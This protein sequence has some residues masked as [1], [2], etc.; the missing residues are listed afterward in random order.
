MRKFSLM[1]LLCFLALGMKAQ[2]LSVSNAPSNG[3]WA[4]NTTWYTIKNKTG[5]YVSTASDYC[6]TEG[7]LRLHNSTKPADNDA[8]AHWC[9]VGSE[10]NG[11]KFYNKASG[12]G[13]ALY[14]SRVLDSGSASFYMEADGDAVNFLFDIANSQKSG[15]I[16]IKD[17]NN[18]NNYWNKRGQNLA[19]WNSTG[20]TNDD[21][22]SFQFVEV[23]V[24]TEL[25]KFNP[26]K[27][28]TVSTSGRGGWSVKEDGSQFCSTADGGLGTNVDAANTRN[29]FAI[30]TVDNENYYLFSVHA[31]K[32][33]KRDRTLVAGPGDP[34]EFAQAGD[35]VRVRVNFKGIAD[36]YIN[37]GGSNQMVINN[38][39]TLDAGN[40]VKFLESG[41]FNP[42]AALA[43]LAPQPD[44]FSTEESPKWHSVEFKTGGHF[45]SDKGNGQNLTTT[46]AAE[47]DA[48]LWIFIGKPEGFK[49]KNRAGNYVT[50]NSGASRFASSSTAAD[51]VEMSFVK[52]KT[53]GTWEIQR[54]GSS[55]CMNQ[56]GGTGV[57]VALGEWTAGDANN[58]VYLN[59]VDESTLETYMEPV[60]SNDGTDNWFMIKFAKNGNH[61]SSGGEG[62]QA[63]TA[64]V[65][66]VKSQWWKFV[67]TADNFQLVNKDG[68]YATMKA[69]TAANGQT[70]N[71]LL[72][73][74]STA[75]EHGFRIEKSKRANYT[76]AYEIRYNGKA[77]DQNSFNQWGGANAGVS[78]GLWTAHSD[79]NNPL[80]IYLPA[81]SLASV[82]DIE[83][84]EDYTPESPLTLWYKNAASNMDVDDKW[85][86]YSLPIGNGQ[87]GA[88]IFGGI[89]REQVQFNE[90]TLWSG[91]KN[92]KSSEYGDYE[93]FGS[94]YI[95]DIS[96]VFGEGKGV[97]N[98]YRQLDLSNATA[99][100]HY[101][102]TDGSINFTREYIAS[103]PD[104]VVAMRLT[105]DKPGNISIN[106]TFEAGRPGLRA[107]TTY[108]NGTASFAGKLETISY[109]AL[110]K[111]VPTNGT[112]TTGE[113]GI[114]V[115]GA[116]EVLIILGGDTDFDAYNPN[117]VS[118]TDEL[119][120]RVEARVNSAAAKDWNALYTAH[121]ED[122]KHYFDRCSFELAG[123]ANTMPTDDLVREYAKRTTGTESYALMLEQLYFAYGRYLEICSSRGV[124]LP[125]NLQ[126]I[127]N[128]S[129]EPAWNADIHANINVQMNYWPAEPTNMSEMHLPFLNYIINMANSAEW[130]KLA[131]DNGATRDE[132]WTFLT[133]NNIFGGF[134][135][136]AS[137]AF[138]NNAWYCSHLWQHY[139]YTLD[140]EFLARAFPAMWGASLF[141][142]ERVVYNEQD[143]TYEC[144][145]EYSPEHGPGAQNATAHSQQLV[146]E[147]FDNTLKA[148]EVL[149]AQN[150]GIDA[151]DIDALKDR[152]S[153][154]D[155]GLA[156]ETYN[157]DW[158]N[159]IA[160]GSKLLREWKYSYYTA[161]QNG[162][163][164]MSHL[165]CL[166]P[167]AQV[168]GESE[169][170][171]AAINSMLLRG[172][173]STGW[174]M[175]W[176]INLWARALDGNHSH[177][178]LELALRHHSVSGGGVYYNL[179]DS[180]S[181]F[182]IDGNFGACAG[183]A[184]MLFQSHSDVL[185][186]LPA[187]PDVWVEGSVK[188]LK[189]V[190]D[191]TVDIDWA[192]NK[193]TKAT[194]VNNQGTKCV[195]KAE[196]ITNAL[197]TVNG[198]EV[199][200]ECAVDGTCCIP[201]NK[202]DKIVIDFTQEPTLYPTLVILDSAKK[203]FSATGTFSK[204]TYERTLSAGKYGTIVLPFEVDDA[205]KAAFEFYAFK[206]KEDGVLNFTQVD[207]PQANVPYLYKN[208]AEVP[209]TAL[210]SVGDYTISSTV[211]ENAANG[212][213]SMV[214]TYSNVSI[215]DADELLVTYAVSNNA[216]RNSSAGLS[217][218]PFRA[219]F[220]GENF[221]DLFPADAPT[222]SLSISITDNNGG[223]TSI[224]PADIENANDGIFYDIYGRRVELPV[225]GI[226]IVNGKKVI[227]K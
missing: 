193:A 59:L 197:I 221:N 141:W 201:S 58:P 56:N 112:M 78:I 82:F 111:V 145:N 39:N 6:S 138:I 143:G 42:T 116:D 129:S 151:K 63:V 123:A 70:S 159:A 10:A 49:M 166:Y 13:K 134:G 227:I 113:K 179:Y 35:G 224:T 147:L 165:M 191:F 65:K 15:Y 133:E 79:D 85:M 226:Y 61:L 92:D 217:F 12:T 50:W 168:T 187:L 7:K 88:S 136:F 152:F 144:P 96:E 72:Y 156:T 103:N 94:V 3:E 209:A 2:V 131:K 207:A 158:G 220:V 5:G 176:K 167:F 205:T 98:Y 149:G 90:K 190:G 11:Y 160:A 120:A 218:A 161:G 198:V 99:S 43:M 102:S 127:W 64:L 86:E 202:G 140:K 51:A 8:N 80:Y 1:M 73:M 22:S 122:F 83:G 203:N 23:G 150:L 223:T 25:A 118:A 180:H 54:V 27:Y 173:A 157:G 188:G 132:A 40:K 126:G 37:L 28:Y 24:V 48:Q 148:I 19:Y 16:V 164:H 142:V 155:T 52:G 34:I 208:V 225:K 139:R 71:H 178:I 114:T 182:Q 170:F 194:I 55:K 17:H 76:D 46:A 95:N 115:T 32:F 189:A 192:A 214:G 14:A 206:G 119:P 171:E 183:I 222:K 20:A 29:Q 67:G 163:R 154:L 31:N 196:G 210:V 135:S 89:A 153:K 146:W 36:S 124:D 121:V 109:N 93:N 199:A 212:E 62:N 130:K 172:D 128:N 18:Q 186:I 101:S 177:D 30:L 107:S 216:I 213:W 125:S 87:F 97:K 75:D 33:I 41:D 100:V 38:Y 57:G 74:Q 26:N 66:N 215:T 60:F 137:T 21:G 195:V 174:S 44:V 106:V 175:G 81:A 162:H 110:V 4:E 84:I 68:C 219:Y 77:G 204:I 53:D 200:A 91:T 169:Y 117:Y 211:V 108:S 181:P 69:G 104:K 47:A 184:E 9:V 105:A 45:L 185:H